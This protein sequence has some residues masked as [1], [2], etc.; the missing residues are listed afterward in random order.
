MKGGWFCDSSDGSD[1]SSGNE[2]KPFRAL[3]AVGDAL[4]GSVPGRPFGGSV[5]R[6]VI[7]AGM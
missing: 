4:K 3:D 6:V 5:T 1:G 2:G 7:E